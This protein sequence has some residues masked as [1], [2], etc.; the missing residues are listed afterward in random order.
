MKEGRG[1]R[2]GGKIDRDT[3]NLVKGRQKIGM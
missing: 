2:V 3:N 1:T